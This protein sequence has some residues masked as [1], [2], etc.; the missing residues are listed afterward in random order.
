SQTSAAFATLEGSTWSSINPPLFVR[1]LWQATQYL[2][3]RARYSVLD[4][5][6]G[7]GE[8]SF[9]GGV[10]GVA[11]YAQRGDR[12]HKDVG[13]PNTRLFIETPPA[14]SPDGRVA[15]SNFSIRLSD[16]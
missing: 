4:A 16:L 6:E 1:S 9:E 11:A 5:A 10:C 12:T 2:L 13:K 3:T 8:E 14:R 7:D 15:P